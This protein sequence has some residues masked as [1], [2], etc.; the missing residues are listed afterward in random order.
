MG[1]GGN[2]VCFVFVCVFSVFPMRMVR[3]TGSEG[4]WLMGKDCLLYKKLKK[5]VEVGSLGAVVWVKLSH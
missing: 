2:G 1:N 5:M 3:D 4:D